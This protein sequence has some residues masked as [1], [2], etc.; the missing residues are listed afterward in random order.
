MC[1]KCAILVRLRRNWEKFKEEY[2]D[3]DAAAQL[4]QQ[5]QKDTDDPYGGL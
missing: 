4:Y 5:A 3:S 1:G 2:G